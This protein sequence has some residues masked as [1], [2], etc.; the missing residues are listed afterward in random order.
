MKITSPRKE[1]IRDGA[2]LGNLRV[3]IFGSR[4]P[5]HN[6]H[7]S[8]K[9]LLTVLAIACIATG[10]STDPEPSNTPSHTIPKPGSTFTFGGVIPDDDSTI[11]TIEATGLE[12]KGKTNVSKFEM[13]G[14]W[15]YIAYE[16]NGDFAYLYQDFTDTV[17]YLMPVVS[18][19]QIVLSERSKIVGDKTE[20]TIVTLT[21]VKEDDVTVEGKLL[22]G[23][24]IEVIEAN[25][26]YLQSGAL[27]RSWQDTTYY[28]WSHDVGFFTHI[29]LGG[30]FDANMK[31]YSLK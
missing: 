30:R 26:T 21:P 10:C 28:T 5:Q 18:K 4:S 12:K 2:T 17:W 23:Y 31:H 16:T 1:R 22:K 27:D 11:A 6:P 29:D 24:Q 7:P 25:K 3:R 14:K 9:Q 13:N 20:K 8:M 19:Q 15:G